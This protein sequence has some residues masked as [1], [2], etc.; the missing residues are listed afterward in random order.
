MACHPVGPND[1]LSRYDRVFLGEVTGARLI[2]RE[3]QLLGRPDGCT[4]PE[5]G[6]EKI[7]FNLSGSSRPVRLF[8][9]PY[10]VAKGRVVG[11]AEVDEAGCKS[12]SPQLGTRALFF[13]RPG[14]NTASVVWESSGDYFN[15]WLK[16]LDIS[17][18]R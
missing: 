2:G 14:S 4:I 11:P 13:M 12:Q 3:N 17:D 7:C 1:D 5:P 6:E 15:G 16:R 8:V 9:I 18:E 10:H